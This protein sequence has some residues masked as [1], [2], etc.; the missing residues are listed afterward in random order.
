VEQNISCLYVYFEKARREV[1]YSIIVKFFT[2]VKLV[3]LI[4]ITKP[5]V[6]SA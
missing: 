3:M 5:V 2:H 4:D 1:S 6:K